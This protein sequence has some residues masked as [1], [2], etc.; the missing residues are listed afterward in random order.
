[1]VQR[2]TSWFLYIYAF[3]YVFT[4]ALK[5]RS[6]QRAT[7]CNIVRKITFGLACGRL[8][9]LILDRTLEGEIGHLVWSV[10]EL[11]NEKRCVLQG[12][13]TEFGLDL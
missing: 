7:V 10:S 11:L 6:Y 1:V 12:M 8:K 13:E 3:S 4:T 2:S 9:L 5:E